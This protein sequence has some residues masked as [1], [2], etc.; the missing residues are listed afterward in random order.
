MK[1]LIEEILHDLETAA[2]WEEEEGNTQGVRAFDRAIHIVKYHS[3]R[4]S[5]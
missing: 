2:R 3:E 1:T 4:E 5:Q